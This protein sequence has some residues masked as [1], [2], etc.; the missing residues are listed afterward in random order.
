VCALAAEQPDN[1]DCNT[2]IEVFD[3]TTT[4]GDTTGYS[5]DHTPAVSDSCTARTTDGPDAVYEVAAN[6]GETIT[7][8]MTPEGWDGALYI[9]QPCST[10]VCLAGSDEPTP[11]WSEA[12]QLVTELAGPFYVIVDG[13]TAAD[14]GC[15]TLVV[16]V[17]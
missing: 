12:V 14:S 6:V 10:Y 15:F 7:A 2:T 11:G 8:T 9:V 4:Y 5:N 16:H 17:N 3:E 1:D 13:A